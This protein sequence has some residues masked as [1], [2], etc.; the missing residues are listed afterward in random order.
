M[1]LFLNDII[2][3]DFFLTFTSCFLTELFF[4]SFDKL[5]RDTK[6]YINPDNGGVY[7]SFIPLHYSYGG[8]F[9]VTLR[10][11]DTVLKGGMVAH[12]E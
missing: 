9:S 4:V 3:L 12:R 8:I 10:V 2:D 7:L 6:V 1:T 11:E 5:G